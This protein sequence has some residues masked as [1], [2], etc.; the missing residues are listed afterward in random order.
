M[1]HQI[2]VQKE[3]TV[4]ICSKHSAFQ[5]DRSWQEAYFQ[6]MS[7]QNTYEFAYQTA[8]HSTHDHE[9]YLWILLR[10]KTSLDLIKDFLTDLGYGDLKIDNVTV[11]EIE[12]YDL[13]VDY[14][15]EV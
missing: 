12:T 5:K 9:A 3:K 15:A 11:G 6:V 10:P 2:E 8:I 4:Q 13:D 14:I 7:Y 1:L